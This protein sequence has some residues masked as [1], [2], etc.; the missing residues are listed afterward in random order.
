MGRTFPASPAR[1]TAARRRLPVVGSTALRRRAAQAV[2][3]NVPFG[4]GSTGPRGSATGP[5]RGDRWR[6]GGSR[7]GVHA[8]AMLGNATGG[9]ALLD[10]RQL[11]LVALDV[12]FDQLVD[13]PVSWSAR[14]A[15][16]RAEQPL[17]RGRIDI[18]STRQTYT[19]NGLYLG[20]LTPSST[21]S[22]RNW[23][24]RS[25]GSR[26]ATISR[27]CRR[28]RVGGVQASRS[29]CPPTPC[30]SQASREPVGR[31][32]RSARGDRAYGR[33]VQRRS[34]FLSGTHGVDFGLDL[35]RG[36]MVIGQ[37]SYL[38]EQAKGDRGLPGI[39][40]FGGFH[41]PADQRQQRQGRQFRLLCDGPAN[42]LP[43]GRS[44]QAEGLTLWLAV[45]YQPQEHQPLPVFLS[46]G[47]CTKA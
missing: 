1:R 3:K 40:S 30:R 16:G 26:A 14:R 39:Y 8:T 37:A 6:D 25:D 15:G 42:G 31:R 11:D 18:C 7:S 43:R 47:A 2:P 19:P 41:A 13:G 36:V 44:R 9:A 10:G 22:T 45:A 23:C 34:A 35:E 17:G 24:C 46:S 4:I 20:Q 33:R 27:A 12:D 28:E 21:C 32:A 29:A 5:A 38:R